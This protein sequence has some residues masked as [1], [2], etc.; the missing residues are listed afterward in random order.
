LYAPE[1]LKAI[2]VEVVVEPVLHGR[3]DT[4]LGLGEQLLDGL[5]HDVRGGMPDDVPAVVAGVIYRLDDVA[6]GDLMSQVAQFAVDPGGDDTGC[7]GT[8]FGRQGRARSRASLDHML[9]TCEGDTKLLAGHGVLLDGRIGDRKTG[10][11]MLSAPSRI[12]R[13]S[14]PGDQG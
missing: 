9:A 6:V 4:Q 5:R 8:S 2:D 3:A 1:D 10:Y 14:I 12:A 7:H 13:V 11:P